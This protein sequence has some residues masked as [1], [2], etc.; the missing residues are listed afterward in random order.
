MEIEIGVTSPQAKE[1]QQPLEDG[2]DKE[3]ILP[4]SF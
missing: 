2:G 3:W 4:W 1:C